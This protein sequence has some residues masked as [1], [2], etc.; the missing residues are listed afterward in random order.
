MKGSDERTSVGPLYRAPLEESQNYYFLSGS[1]PSEDI[2]SIFVR[3]LLRLASIVNGAGLF[4][5]SLL[6]VLHYWILVYAVLIVPPYLMD[7]ASGPILF[8]LIPFPGFMTILYIGHGGVEFV[9]YFL[10]IALLLFISIFVMIRNDGR[11]F[12]GKIRSFARNRRAPAAGDTNSFIMIYQMFMAMLFLNTLI[13][14]VNYLA[15]GSS[16][17]VPDSLVNASFQ[18][19]LY[20]LANASVYEEFAARV[21]YLGLPLY[22]VARF[23][24]RAD[25]PWY[26]YLIGGDMKMDFSAYFFALFSSLLFGMAH[27]EGWGVWKIFPT[28]ISG[29]MFAYIFLRKGV[30]SA[31]VF[32]FLFDYISM[33]NEALAHVG[34]SSVLLDLVFA[35]LLLLWVHLGIRYLVHY[36]L[37]L[38]VSV[39]HGIVCRFRPSARRPRI[40]FRTE[41]AVSIAVLALF[42][43][44]G[45]IC[46]VKGIM[47][48]RVDS[49]VNMMG[50]LLNGYSC[51]W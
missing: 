44:I 3:H 32:H 33:A 51:W 14:M 50:P 9:V 45:L 11:D 6:P 2:P 38:A 27:L 31:I 17:S 43:F 1:T 22:L 48:S 4:A 15:V 23:T 10:V 13:I 20:S 21:L 7:K 37:R 30:F 28:V 16:P 12:L 35:V 47:E 36:V 18:G 8:G 24:K 26:R 42:W 41:V 19:K 29:L 25:R 34:R 39:Y 46:L 5:M 49:G 40:G